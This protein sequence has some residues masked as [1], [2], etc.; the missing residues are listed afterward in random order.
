MV[1]DV[2]MGRVGSTDEVATAVLWL[3][4]PEASYITGVIV[5]ISGGR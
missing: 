3:L 2:P 4:S 1:G 5:P